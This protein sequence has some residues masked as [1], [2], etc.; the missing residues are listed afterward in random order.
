MGENPQQSNLAQSSSSGE[1]Q[2]APF[3]CYIDQTQKET[4]VDPSLVMN[5]FVGYIDQTQ[6]ET[7]VDPPRS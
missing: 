4:A 7:T 2:Q 3:V 5:N 1:P 6:E